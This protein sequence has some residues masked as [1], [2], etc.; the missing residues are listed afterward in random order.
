MGKEEGP[1]DGTNDDYALHPNKR[2]G[3]EQ[4]DNNHNTAAVAKPRANGDRRIARHVSKVTFDES[5]H[6]RSSLR[7]Q[8]PSHLSKNVTRCTRRQFLE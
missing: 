3:E 5:S 6:S 2:L 1:M 4:A 7:T 8:L